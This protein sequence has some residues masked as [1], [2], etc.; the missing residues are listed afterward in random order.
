MNKFTTVISATL[1][2]SFS[3]VAFS[4][5]PTPPPAYNN[6]PDSPAISSTNMT[7]SERAGFALYEQAL[8]VTEAII[9][10]RGCSTMAG[11][12]TFVSFANGIPDD[13]DP[14]NNTATILSTNGLLVL[15]ADPRA[16]EAFQGQKFDMNQPFDGT[17]NTIA[18]NGGP[19][20][21]VTDVA[22]YRGVATYNEDN[23]IL[24]QGGRVDVTGA[25]NRFN[26]YQERIIKDFYQGSLG[27]TPIEIIDWGLQVLNKEGYPVDKYWQRSRACRSDGGSGDITF[28][29]DRLVGDTSCRI[30]IA[31]NGT[32]N[33][34]IFD[35]AGSL[36]ISVQD[37]DP[38]YT[39]GECDT[40]TN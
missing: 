3:S 26:R 31:T 23:N 36:T 2:A 37:P 5:P 18:F 33:S 6:G 4:M 14:P 22:N 35:Q 16:P 15:N 19:H 7:E 10:A 27:A 28:V 8:H 20:L 29:K 34:D 30:V 38:A 9:H 25:N 13:G 11:S 39:F 17:F 21:L 32:N 24:F 40:H 1:M 12:Y